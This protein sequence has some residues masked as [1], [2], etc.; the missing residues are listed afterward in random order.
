MNV[1]LDIDG[2]LRGTASPVS[3]VVIF[4]EYILDNFAD[5][6]YWLTTHCR[7][8][9]NH[10]REA[11]LDSELPKELAE[12][13]ANIIKP[14]DFGVLKT[15][16]IDFSK[17]F[18]WFDDNLFQSEQMVLEKHGCLSSHFLMDPSDPEM[19]KKALDLLKLLREEQNEY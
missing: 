1:Y 12:R 14:T 5:S 19:A 4:L 7:Q 2:V 10:C 13:A 11:L 16:G 9:Y 8:G 17:P 18:V 3:D 6:T 15:E